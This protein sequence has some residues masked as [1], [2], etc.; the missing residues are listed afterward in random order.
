MTYAQQR[1]DYLET[2]F[3]N[4][5]I[6][7]RFNEECEEFMYYDTKTD[8]WLN[9]DGTIYEPEGEGNLFSEDFFPQDE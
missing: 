7:E 5:T 4:G 6:E 8:E 9:N 2:G 1:Q 3:N